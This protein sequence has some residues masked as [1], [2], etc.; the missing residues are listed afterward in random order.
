MQVVLTV[1]SV[2][3]PVALVDAVYQRLLG[4]V[5]NGLGC[6]AGHAAVLELRSLSVIEH[7]LENNN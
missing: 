3:A 2:Y 5:P 1:Y 7:Q 4:D 6:D